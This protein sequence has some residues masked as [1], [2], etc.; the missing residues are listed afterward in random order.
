MHPNHDEF[1]RL[2]VEDAELQSPL[3][4]PTDSERIHIQTRER[5][6]SMGTNERDSE[7]KRQNRI[8][9][10]L[11]IAT[12]VVTFFTARGSS[13]LALRGEEVGHGH[14]ALSF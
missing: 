11:S 13:S 6:R 2:N 8:L 4:S 10:M 9:V 5:A 3:Q 7:Q 1:E 12:F 14:G